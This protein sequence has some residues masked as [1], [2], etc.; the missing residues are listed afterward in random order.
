MGSDVVKN[1]IV[2]NTAHG[3]LDAK[4]NDIDTS[5]FVLKTKYAADKSELDNKYPDTSG[6][7][8]KLDYNANITEI[9]GKIPSINDFAWT[10]ALTAVESKIPDASS[11][12][13]K[14]RKII[15][16][17][18]VILKRKL[19]IITMINIYLLQS[20]ISLQQ[21]FLLKD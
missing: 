17:K 11:L 4:V 19:L 10:S 7:V 18:L 14:K 3:K 2:K 5:G 1:N 15:I 21:K 16:Q 9:E 12:A 6:L 13:K 20:L 8:K